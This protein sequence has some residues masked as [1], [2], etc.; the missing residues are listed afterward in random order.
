[1]SWAT[2]TRS[3]SWPVAP[4]GRRHRGS[5]AGAWDAAEAHFKEAPAICD[6][7]PVQVGQGTMREFYADMLMM[8][9]AG[10]DRARWQLVR[11]TREM[12]LE[13]QRAFGQNGA[14]DRAH[15]G[16]VARTRA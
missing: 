14:I 2:A 16:S 11:D 4:R 6:T 5:C 13:R 3:R 15:R 12:P 10:D 7:T 9:N 1:M 8:R